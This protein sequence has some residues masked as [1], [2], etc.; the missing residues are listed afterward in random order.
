VR[1][2]DGTILHKKTS[3]FPVRPGAG[4]PVSFCFVERDVAT[5]ARLQKQLH[6]SKKMEALGTLAGSIAHDFNNMLGGIMACVE[7]AQDTLAEDSEAGFE[8]G[9]ALKACGYAKDMIRQILTFS[10]R[11][12]AAKSPLAM[13]PLV[14][15][16][17][18]LACSGAP[19]T[20]EARC[21]I[22]AERDVVLGDPGRISQVVMNLCTNAVQAM[23]PDGGVLT[24]SLS[25]VVLTD[26]ETRLHPGL[27]A[28]PYLRL[29]VADTGHGMDSEIMERIFDPFFTT[30]A[31]GG[32]VGLGLSVVH[33]IVAELG[34]QITVESEPGRGSTFSVLLPRAVQRAAPPAAGTAAPPKGAERILFVE[35]EDLLASA[36]T[37]QLEGFGYTVVRCADGLEALAAFTACPDGF[38]LVMTDLTMPGMTGTELARRI[39]DTRPDI[40]VLLCTGYAD[41]LRPEEAAELGVTRILAKPFVKAEVATLVR[42]VLDRK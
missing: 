20:I 14:R 8:L 19:R 23:L 9:E 39:R 28:G 16:G 10:R 15:E 12:E 26:A 18:H 34:G 13:A 24:V 7:M 37:R 29:T 25:D 27:P 1:R 38:D 5:E 4:E 32:G 11:G 22:Q 6:H 2:P 17:L 3:A 30:K 31:K 21:S 42:H 41:M 35:D 40:P 33:G 36:L